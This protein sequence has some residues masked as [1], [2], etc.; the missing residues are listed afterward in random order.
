VGDQ[1][2]NPITMSLKLLE[3]YRELLKQTLLHT[4][5]P[6]DVEEVIRTLQ[7]DQGLFLS[8]NRK[9]KKAPQ[10]FR[11]FCRSHGL[12][13][14]IPDML[15][16]MQDLY[17]HQEEAILSILEGKTTIVST[18]TGSGKTEAFLVPIL[19]HCLKHRSQGVKAI[20]IYPMNALA[21]DQVRRLKSATADSPVTFGL[22][23]GATSEDARNT[24]RRQPPDI[25]ITNYVMLDW[26]LTR[27]ADQPIF[28]ASRDSLRFIVLD[29]IHTYR[30]NKATHL[31]FLLARLRACFT[32]PVVQVGTSATLQS[33]GTRGYLQPNREHLD[34]FVKA[35]L[36]VDSY[37]FIEPQYEPDDEKPEERWG[38]YLP[39][40]NE[41][42]GWT[43]QANPRTGLD[44]VGRL[45]GK[46]YSEID[47]AVDDITQAQ[48]F[49]DLKEHPFIRAMRIALVQKGSQSLAELSKILSS[50]LPADYPR[51]RVE[52]LTKAFLS[53][54]AF[55]NYE[56]GQSGTPLLDFRIHL[57]LQN[58][59]GHLKR[60][61]KCG[62]Y[63]SGNQENCSDCG[64]PL[65]HVYRDDTR[66]CIGK[67][68]GNRLKWELQPESDDRNNAYYVLISRVDARHRENQGETLI[69]RDNPEA[70]GNGITLKY[71]EYGTL[72]LEVLSA[73]GY[74]SVRQRTIPL[75]DEAHRYQYLHSL[76]RSILDF[77][78]KPARKLLAF[79]DNREQASQ[80]ATILQDEFASQFF[81]E[82]LKYSLPQGRAVD[83]ISARDLMRRGI[84][85][86]ENRTPLE[87][88]VFQEID[89]WYWRFLG[90][91]R[92]Q[93]SREQDLLQ[94]KEDQSLTEFE[95]ELLGI[96][97]AERAIAKDFQQEPCD[98]RCIKFEKEYATD[99]KGI[100]CKTGNG[101]KDPRYPSIS[102][103]EH[104]QEY[105]VFVQKYGLE[106]IYETV[107]QLVERGWL[108][109][110]ETPDGKVHYY[111]NPR[112]V[113][114]HLPPSLYSSYDEIR[115]QRLLTAAVH[116]SEV[117]DPDRQQ[118]ERDFQR[119]A[120]N[121]VLATP[122][123]EMGIDVGKLQS[124]LM[125]GFPPLPSN[126]AQRAGRAGRGS[127]Q[128]YALIVTF[129]SDIN[130][131]DRFYFRQPKTMIDGV[132]TPPSFNPPNR[133]ILEKHIN[134]FVLAGHVSSKEALQ[135][136]CANIDS[137]IQKREGP[138]R[139]VF[140]DNPWVHQYL[141]A[142]FREQVLNMAKD[143]IASRSITPQQFFY[144]SGFFPDY[145]FRRDQ[146]YLVDEK[147][148][149]SSARPESTLADAALSEREP[150][151]AYHKFS[152]GEIVFV[153]GNVYCISTDGWYQAYQDKPEE[154]RAYKYFRV[155][156]QVRYAQR[157]KLTNKYALVQ[158]F[159]NNQPFLDK[160]KVMGIAFHP[161][162]RLDFV[163]EGVRK[164]DGYKPFSDEK[165]RFSL[166]YRIFR[167]AI[168]LRFDRRVCAD[169]KTYLSLVSALYRGIKETYK[170]DES[171][172]RLLID[173][174][175]EPP[176]ASEEEFT[177]VVLYEADGNGNVP[178]EVMYQNFDKI[179]AAT[180]DTL[181]NCTCEAGC[182][183]CLRNHATNYF[184]A[185]LDKQ[186]A[187]MFLGYLLGKNPFRPS[188]AAIQE[189]VAQFDLELRLERKGNL[190]TVHR[191][192]RSYSAVLAGDQNKTIC[193]LLIQAIQA[194]YTP[195]MES[196]RIKAR[197]DYLVR[198][199][200][201]GNIKRNQDEFARLQFNLLRF[202]KVEATRMNNDEMPTDPNHENA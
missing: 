146:V 54:V 25:L 46:Q 181:V 178:M 58:I 147:W 111:L 136:F 122:T 200:N 96:F 148:I 176:E 193:E 192:S 93:T 110:G 86:E 22:F 47:L 70:N 61:L 1:Y 40:P 195:G 64:Y 73:G 173:A 30:G 126:Y 29:E 172:I 187:L 79:I 201:G 135:H 184:G 62:T 33:D 182:Y 63:H 171:E 53:A 94:L 159:T 98:T 14:R 52:D 97:L 68:S 108:V 69:F 5:K 38:F 32:G 57:V 123:L 90:Q 85:V 65:F 116:S 51:H 157:H 130:E 120:L 35:L 49:R 162:C 83:I 165:G 115:D 141:K 105:G 144:E 103:A 23:T 153:A 7:V 59:G 3:G 72:R 104:A 107:L 4:L 6:D 196:L 119:G 91:P 2:I 189:D 9:Y 174:R 180:Y 77:Q 10:P 202:S 188:I 163:N 36:E 139:E 155:S 154:M 21:N 137:Q 80:Y 43:L 87:Q 55:A 177:Y 169:D 114:L 37:E 197:E 95:R 143:A 106:R 102:L 16:Y 19:D 175:P 160:G 34:H 18:G 71:D 149:G 128:Q 121:L 134:A 156:P 109:E 67:V 133:E 167:K 138:I 140:G 101:S 127:R 60:C 42:L 164:P 151:I 48:F 170:L 20:I 186:V 142:E 145:S 17:V 190:Y 198:A 11:Q 112:Q 118:I 124:V 41:E 8:L 166:G 168:V 125:I 150:E 76:V 81:E 132:I 78:P 199:I 131:H 75:V 117:K 89:L 24:I 129:C 26:M 161:N 179:L 56:A 194:E 82:F 31:K 66:R 39:D 74:E 152:P 100:H 183:L 99:R 12:D 15:P 158:I 84:P 27:E 92:R 28:N 113:L 185:K 50:L 44:N 45:M 88:E 13:T 191:P